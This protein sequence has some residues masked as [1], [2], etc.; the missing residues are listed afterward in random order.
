VNDALRL[1]GQMKRKKGVHVGSIISSVAGRT[2]HHPMSVPAGSYVLPAD[3]V[4]SLGE[5]NTLSGM[6]VVNKMFSMGPYGSEPARKPRADGGSVEKPI[7]IVAAGGEVV[8]P[9]EKITER[10]GDLDRGHAALDA[11]VIENRKHHIKTLSELPG[12]AQD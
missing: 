8:I 4:S 9:P 1:V 5:G 2:D 6:E 12:P 7:E 10:F 3:H 11:W